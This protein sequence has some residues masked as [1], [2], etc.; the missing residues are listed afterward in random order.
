M[1][2]LYHEEN[3]QTK[4]FFLEPSEF[5]GNLLPEHDLECADTLFDIFQPCGKLNY[6]SVG[7]I[8]DRYIQN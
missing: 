8:S 4:Y 7:R 6:E 1:T 2:D 3:K 5:G